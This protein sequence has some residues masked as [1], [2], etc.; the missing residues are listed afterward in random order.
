MIDVTV[1]TV[2]QSNTMA[3][4][5]K[6]VGYR[7]TDETRQLL[8]DIAKASGFS[9]L[10]QYLD[11]VVTS[12]IANVDPDVMRTVNEIRARRGQQSLRVKSPKGSTVRRGEKQG[13]PN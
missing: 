11:A 10:Q 8:E 7:L 6:Q 5:K 12:L 1:L 9:S 4:E 2:L 13:A 3:D